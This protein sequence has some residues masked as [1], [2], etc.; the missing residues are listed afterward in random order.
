MAYYRRTSFRSLIARTSCA[1]LGIA[2][3]SL[4]SPLNLT[5]DFKQGRTKAEVLHEQLKIAVAVEQDT[6]IPRGLN[7]NVQT[8]KLNDQ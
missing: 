2:A 1:L 5:L 4:G 6:K 7:S 3:D 8:T